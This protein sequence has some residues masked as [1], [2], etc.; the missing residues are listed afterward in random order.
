M[1]MKRIA[2]NIAAGLLCCTLTTALTGCQGDELSSQSVMTDDGLQYHDPFDDWLY[3]NYTVP[4][5][6]R[7]KYHMED[8]ESEYEY[9]LAPA[10]YDKAV[11]VAHIFKYTW[12]EAYDEICGVDFTRRYVPKV[13]HLVGSAAYARN[14]TI[15][16]G[17]AEGGMKITLYAVNQLQL[18]HT[19]LDLYFH[20]IHHEFAHI[21][22]Q[23]KDYPPDFEKIS[24]GR[25]VSGDWY[26][27]TDQHA[28][29][30]GFVSAYAM[31][32]PREDIAELTAEYITHD[33]DYWQKLMSNAGQQGAAIIGMKLDILRAYMLSAW[34]IDIDE[35]RDIIQR[36]VDDVI[37]GKII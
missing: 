14:G 23:T 25:Y 32:E 7:L 15:M 36:R 31:S 20:T 10:D 6:I 21:L 11:K 34:N 29:Q 17:Q 26:L 33:A 16:M 18:N 1:T 27:E 30:T 12:L 19:F 24:E 8:I 9:T 3:M 28:L 5:N 13:M 2:Y 35:L 37:E 4:Y 22:H